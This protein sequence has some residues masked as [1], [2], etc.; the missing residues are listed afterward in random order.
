MLVHIQWERDFSAK[1]NEGNTEL[2]LVKQY[3]IL[4]LI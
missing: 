3:F 4:C 2:K 1:K